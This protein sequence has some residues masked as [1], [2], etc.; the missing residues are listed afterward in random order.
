MQTT[1][2]DL[3]VEKTKE[4]CQI[5][6]DQPNVRSAR[7][8][9]D[10]FMSD[11]KAKAQYEGVVHKGRALHEKQQKS[12]ALTGEEI[13]SFEH[14]RDALLKN[15]VAKGFIDAQEHMQG[16]HESINQYVA[17]ALELGRVPAEDDFGGGSCGDGGCGCGHKH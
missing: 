10:K 3:I 4:L 17:K 8:Q 5:I 13:S 16:I 14:E 1:T 9:I 6:L 12:Q 7:Q 15:P 11:D 2:Q